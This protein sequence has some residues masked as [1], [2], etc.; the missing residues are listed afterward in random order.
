MPFDGIFI[1]KLCEELRETLKNAKVLKIYQPGA[2]E[3][4]IEFRYGK[5][6]FISA[7]ASNPYFCLTD[8][9]KENPAV[10]PN[11]CML[12]RKHLNGAMLKTIEQEGFER[13]VRLGFDSVNELGDTE[14]KYLYIEIMGKYCNIILTDF[15]NKILGAIK[16]ENGEKGPRTIMPGIIYT[17]LKGKEKK[18]ITEITSEEVKFFASSR[19][20]VDGVNGISPVVS[21]TLLENFNKNGFEQTITEIADSKPYLYYSEDSVPCEFSYIKLN[22]FDNYEIKSCYSD[23]V[24]AFFEHKTEKNLA[25]QRAGDLVR[26]ISSA[27]ERIEHKTEKQNQEKKESENANKYKEYADILTA[28]LYLKAD[29][30]DKITLPNFYDGMNEVT[31]PLEPS[32]DIKANAAAYYKKYKKLKTAA[33]ILEEQIASNLKELEYLKSAKFFLSESQSETDLAEIREELIQNGFLKNKKQYNTRNS[34]QKPKK[35]I[36]YEYRFKENEEETLVLVGKNNVQN[37]KLTFKIAQ[38]NYVWLHVKD[39]PGSHT[40]IC[41]EFKSVS[42]ELLLFAAKTAAKHSSLQGKVSVD[43]TEIKNVKRQPNS[44]PG[45]V[46]Y[47]DY[48]TVVVET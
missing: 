16:T 12:L 32:K 13:T 3:I 6:L 18:D 37:D 27:I 29:K 17:S 47:V 35:L 41:K 7:D 26:K 14:V 31:I 30:A 10:P 21:K 36:P 43:Y 42:D 1:S 46:F 20:L 40:V 9:P 15:S 19:E 39:A 11:F 8:K 22:N 23:A 25:K 2:K 28:N 38:K 33:V 34:K 44:K 4:T 48:K 5:D 45:M 24:E